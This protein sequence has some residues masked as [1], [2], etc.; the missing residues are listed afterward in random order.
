MPLR[1]YTSRSLPP[2]ALAA[3]AATVSGELIRPSD[4]GYGE[5]RHVWNGMIDRYPAV[6]LRCA[7][8]ADVAAGIRFARE[9][10]VAIAV[11]AGGHNVAG[12]GTCDNGLVLDLSGMRGV[13]LDAATRTARIGGGHTWG[14]FDAAV[15]GA[16][17]H[18][19]GGLVSTTGVSGF[20]LGGGIGWLMR[21]HGLACDNL[22]G[23]EVVTADGSLVRTDERENPD[24]LWGL[25]GGG[26]NFGVVVSMTFSMHPVTSVLGGMAFFPAEQAR[27]VLA[28]FVEL[29][30]TAP[31]EL[32]ALAALTTAPPAPFVPPSLHGRPVIAIAVCHTGD[33]TVGE[34]ALAPIRALGPAADLYG[35]MPYVGLQSMLDPTA[36]AGQRQYWKAGYLRSLEPGLV[37][38]LLEWAA[39]KPV[40]F[41]QIHLHQMG[42]A[43]SQVAPDATAFTHRDAAFT[44]NIL[45][46][47]EGTEGDEAGIAWARGTFAAVEQWTDGTYVNFLGA[48]GED[49]VRSAYGPVAHARLAELK[50]QYDPDNVFHLN[51]N[52]RPAGAP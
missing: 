2:A 31:D 28:A 21:R 24:L 32:T 52:I 26:G 27:D 38:A 7:S 42:G 12:Y 25:R 9:A 15:D 50:R 35:P 23:A 13:E 16:G 30:A 36:P 45:G 43:V 10:D 20:T 29:T 46:A 1:H 34:R 51:Q 33:H 8:G 48:E 44:L 41:S 47:W 4:P 17:L 5:A 3:L 19:T 37:D 6:I 14:S 40:P 49:R 22:I 18:T 11:R 39:R